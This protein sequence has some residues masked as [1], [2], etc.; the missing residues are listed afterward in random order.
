MTEQ[1]WRFPEGEP[2]NESILAA[3]VLAR[4][5]AM[6]RVAEYEAKEAAKAAAEAAKAAAEAEGG[7]GEAQLTQPVAEG[8]PVGG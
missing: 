1:P 7:D 8:E 6:R 4:K 2:S 5:D 3:L